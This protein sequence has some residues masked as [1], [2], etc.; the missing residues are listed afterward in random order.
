MNGLP[1]TDFSFDSNGN[2]FAGA[3]IRFEEFSRDS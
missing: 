1:E 2:E 3:I